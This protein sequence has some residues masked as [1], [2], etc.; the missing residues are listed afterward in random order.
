[1]DGMMPAPRLPDMIAA[2]SVRDFQLIGKLK[3]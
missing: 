3:N 2:G 1:M